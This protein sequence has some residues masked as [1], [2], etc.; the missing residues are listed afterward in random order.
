MNQDSTPRS[1]PWT[2]M[3]QNLQATPRFFGEDERL[4]NGLIGAGFFG[5]QALNHTSGQ[6]KLILNTNDEVRELEFARKNYGE[7]GS[8]LLRQLTDIETQVVRELYRPKDGLVLCPTTDNLDWGA[9]YTE[10]HQVSGGGKAKIVNGVDPVVPMVEAGAKPIRDD[11]FTALVGYQLKYGRRVGNELGI[12]F[13]YATECDALCYEALMGLLDESLLNL[14]SVGGVRGFLAD[15]EGRV[16]N[17]TLPG[18]GGGEYLKDTSATEIVL[19]TASASALADALIKLVDDVWL[20]SSKTQRANRLAIPDR[21]Y[22][23][24]KR[25]KRDTGTDTTVMQYVHE[26]SDLKGTP[27]EQA[28][29]AV[30]DFKELIVAKGNQ[31]ARDVVC[32]YNYN[33][34]VVSARI[35]TPRRFKVVEKTMG[36]MVLWAMRF[37]PAQWKRPLGIQIRSAKWS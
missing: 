24:I 2:L 22:T 15:K 31:A 25:L 11:V 35:M 28:F 19:S 3:N 14:S 6:A 5:G 16:G 1:G 18:A 17:Y 32:A 20:L 13:D 30:T 29:V 37:T 34:L 33:P 12:D 9:E 26:N 10:Y 7:G 23:L 27:I 36:E 4:G 8:A 21:L